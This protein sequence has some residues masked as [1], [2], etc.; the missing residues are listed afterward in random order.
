MFSFGPISVNASPSFVDFR[1]RK[2][3]GSTIPWMM[4]RLALQTW[5]SWWNFIRSI[6]ASCLASWSTI[7]CVLPCE[8]TVFPIIYPHN[9]ALIGCS[10]QKEGWKQTE[11]HSLGLTLNLQLLLD[12]AFSYSTWLRKDWFESSS[13]KMTTFQENLQFLVDLRID[14]GGSLW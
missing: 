13:S 4:D 6:G 5:S 12:H 2:K 3:D 9:W 1:V 14:L 11:L 10:Q 8:K 7:A